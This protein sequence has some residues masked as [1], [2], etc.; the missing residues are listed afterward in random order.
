MEWKQPA[1]K[2]PYQ[3]WFKRDGR[4][5]YYPVRLFDPPLR[6]ETSTMNCE[7]TLCITKTCDGDFDVYQHC[8]SCKQLSHVWSCAE[9]GQ[10]YCLWASQYLFVNPFESCAENNTSWDDDEYNICTHCALT[11]YACHH[12]NCDT[13]IMKLVSNLELQARHIEQTFTRNKTF[14]P[15]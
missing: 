11:K 1:I 8:V 15:N 7:N 10:Y 9:C 6:P 13:F 3:D 14:D 12:S 4:F 5:M 2:I